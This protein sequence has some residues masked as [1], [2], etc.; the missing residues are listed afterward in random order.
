VSKGGAGSSAK[1]KQREVQRRI[2]AAA[3][4]HEAEQ[5]QAEAAQQAVASRLLQ[6]REWRVFVQCRHAIQGRLLCLWPP[7]AIGWY[8]SEQMMNEAMGRFMEQT[9]ERLAA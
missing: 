1:A 2:A 6:E 3:A 7:D 8:I 5:E 9:R 4:Q